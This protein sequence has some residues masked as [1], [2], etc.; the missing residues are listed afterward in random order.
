MQKCL[1]CHKPFEK[2]QIQKSLFSLSLMGY[3]DIQCNHCGEVH[4]VKFQT[5]MFYVLFSLAL[6]FG[7]RFFGYLIPNLLIVPSIFIIFAALIYFGP[8]FAW[9][10]H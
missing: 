10:K 6:L 5:R 8:Y 2:K 7:L 9:Y 1:S 4:K 3:K